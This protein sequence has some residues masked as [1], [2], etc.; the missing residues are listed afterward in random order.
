MGGS[1]MWD[2]YGYALGTDAIESNN[3][4]NSVRSDYA[5]MDSTQLLNTRQSNGN[6]PTI[7]FLTPSTNSPLIN[8]GAN[9][10]L[11]YNGSAPDRFY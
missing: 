8:T 4:W 7:T 6:L 1:T 9:V 5:S 11:P 3:R 2:T 10:G